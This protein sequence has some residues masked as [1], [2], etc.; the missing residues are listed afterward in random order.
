MIVVSLYYYICVDFSLVFWGIGL[1]FYIC[2][3]V[4]DREGFVLGKDGE[5]IGGI[6][7]EG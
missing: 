7:F 6:C 5:G 1:Y 2:Y 4:I 3:G